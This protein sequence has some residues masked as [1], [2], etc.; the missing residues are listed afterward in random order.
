DCRRTRA[1]YRTQEKLFM[2]FDARSKVAYLVNR[3]TN[4]TALLA[5]YV[6][7][8][9]QTRKRRAEQ[10]REFYRNLSAYCR[11]NNLNPICF[12]DWKSA[13]YDTNDN[14]LSMNSKGDVP[15]TKKANL[16]R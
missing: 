12:D 5:C 13:A 6:R 1:P 9:K 14:N 4:G 10:E 2:S 15:W 16:P 8:L 11:A 7:G 3:F